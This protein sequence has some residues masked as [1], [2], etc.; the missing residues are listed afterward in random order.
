M[1]ASY[2]AR[3]SCIC[4]DQPLDV[5]SMV[6]TAGIH[7]EWP[8]Q[9]IFFAHLRLRLWRNRLAVEVSIGIGR[10][11]LDPVSREIQM[12]QSFLARGLRD[13]Q[14]KVGLA[15]EVQFSVIPGLDQRIIQIRLLVD[16]RD[17]VIQRDRHRAHG[18]QAPDAG[19]RVVHQPL[20]Q[21]SDVDHIGFQACDEGFADQFRSV[22]SPAVLSINFRCG[23]RGAPDI[24]VFGGQQPFE[25]R[26]EGLYRLGKQ[27]AQ[28]YQ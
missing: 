12:L 13:R 18:R 22:H 5:L 20:E 23:C 27:A 26:L 9:T 1:L 6:D 14:Q 28:D 8:T 4:P 15:Q 25:C 2:R 24:N 11:V 10:D 21:A 7:H 19:D 17:Q 16:E 3:E